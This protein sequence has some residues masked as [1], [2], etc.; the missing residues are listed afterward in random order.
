MNA[1]SLRNATFGASWRKGY[2]EGYLQGVRF[3]QQRYGSLFEGTS[4]IIPTHNQLELLKSC[5]ERVERHTEL[6]YELIVIDNASTDGTLQYLQSQRGQVRSR[7][8]DEDLGFAAAVNV[9]FMMANGRT[10]VVLNNEMAVTNNWLRNLLICLKS[11]DNI[12]M[13]GPVTNGVDGD[14]QIQV[15]D[16]DK[17]QLA[18]L[19]DKHN[20]SNPDLWYDAEWLDESCLLFRRELFE[21]IGYWDEGYEARRDEVKDYNI[22]VKLAGKRLV[23]AAD[24]FIQHEDSLKPVDTDVN[25]HNEARYLAKWRDAE[26]WERRIGDLGGEMRRGR[27]APPGTHFYP[28]WVAVQGRGPAVYW[29]E[30][31]L[32]H[33]IEGPISIPVVHVSQLDLRRW[34]LGEPVKAAHIER[35]WRGRDQPPHGLAGIVK[36]QDGPTYHAEGDVLRQVINL[37]AMESWQLHLKLARVVLPEALNSLP[38]GLPIMPLPKLRQRL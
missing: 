23:I 7:S 8:F 5:L 28:Q 20:C 11:D 6:P 9:G 2:K 3:G 19:P 4:I 30:T 21:E 1:K 15:P 36:L 31:G 17:E 34:P 10:I 13:V 37:H 29:I 32:R 18:T 14:Q 35:K 38:I 24:T 25:V 27:A 16:E 12:G 26:T 33:P 22:R